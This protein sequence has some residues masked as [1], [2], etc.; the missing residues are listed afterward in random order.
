MSDKVQIRIEF[1]KV[2]FI[3]ITV[4]WLC[5]QMKDGTYQEYDMH[6]DKNRSQ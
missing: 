4:D 3:D 2:D 6:Q 1:S 5:I